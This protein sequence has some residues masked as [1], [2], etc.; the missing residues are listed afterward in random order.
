MVDCSAMKQVVKDCSRYLKLSESDLKQWLTASASRMAK[1]TKISRKVKT[2]FSKKDWDLTVGPGELDVTEE[3]H[4]FN[5][6]LGVVIEKLQKQIQHVKQEQTEQAFRVL[7]RKCIVAKITGFDGQDV[8][9]ESDM[10]Q[11]RL[12]Q[13]DRLTKD[14]LA[15]AQELMVFVES[16][17]DSEILVSRVH[18]ELVRNSA[19]RF[20]REF[21]TG[22]AKIHSVARIPGHRAMIAFTSKKPGCLS[23]IQRQLDR[24][25]KELGEK[26]EVV[27]VQPK[28]EESIALAFGYPIKDIA[29]TDREATVSIIGSHDKAE[30]AERRTLIE[31]LF[32]LA[33]RTTEE[34]DS[35]C[36]TA[37]F[38]KRV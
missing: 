35:D 31:Q 15:V 32:D 27:E 1:D 4:V 16:K 21:E 3:E 23:K 25:A 24:V 5:V 19:M 34:K 14:A 37:I 7:A 13:K 6:V 30:V 8:L 20:I 11:L 22:T 10:Q 2:G 36:D 18:T 26:L 17:N 28:M 38:V 33:V 29:V 9:L 12:K